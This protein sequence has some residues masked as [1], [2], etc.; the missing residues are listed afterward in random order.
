MSTFNLQIRRMVLSTITHF[1]ENQVHLLL[2][3]LL[4]VETQL[5]L[6]KRFLSIKLLTFLKNKR[7]KSMLSTLPKLPH[8]QPPCAITT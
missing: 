1:T 8:V 2:Q 4:L 7:T 5:S 3:R 6:L